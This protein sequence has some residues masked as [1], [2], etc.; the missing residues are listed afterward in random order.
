M[1]E[2]GF[3]SRPCHRILAVLTVGTVIWG[4][5]NAQ[6]WASTFYSLPSRQ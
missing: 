6:I 1:L 5:A 4:I 3:H 2:E